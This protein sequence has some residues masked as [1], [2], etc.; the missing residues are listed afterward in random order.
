M[1]L[2]PKDFSKKKYQ[3]FTPSSVVNKILDDLGYNGEDILNKTILESSCG[4]GNFLVEIVE[5]FIRESRKKQW[6]LRRIK[7][8]LENSI[9]GVE[10]DIELFN[11]CIESL[12]NIAMKHEIS[13]VNWKIVNGNGLTEY[14]NY[15]FDFNVGNPPYIRYHGMSDELR[16]YLKNNY[17]SCSKGSFDYFFAFVES[18]FN[19]LGLNGKM[20]FL[21]PG[22]ILTTQSA[23]ILRK[24]LYPYLYKIYD[25]K[26]KKIFKNINTSSVV[27]YLQK[28]KDNIKNFK[29]MIDGEEN[30][31]EI[32]KTS[33]TSKMSWSLNLDEKNNT[34]K[35]SSLFLAHAPIATQANDVFVINKDLIIK[36]KIEKKILKL[37]GSPKD[38]NK[39]EKTYIIFPY[40]TQKQGI[41]KYS[42]EEFKY[43]FP[44]ATKY[45]QIK[46]DR[47]SNRDADKNSQWFEYGRSQAL[48]SVYYSKLVL[49]TSISQKIK[50]YDMPKNTLASGGIVI[51]SIS[52][53]NLKVAKK[54]LTSEEFFIYAENRGV[55]LT[56]SYVRINS[57]LINNFCF[58]KAKL[59]E[60]V[61]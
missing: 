14:H 30:Y 51:K 55:S 46:R 43:N 59:D 42:E 2:E 1:K 39:S 60:W 54:I 34:I 15:N 3:I 11:K 23:S 24:I 21:L 8:G 36:Y 32:V 41:H 4:T 48:Q 7:K 33:D 25:F 5:R 47:L 35:F 16:N 6:N 27:I 12:N 61:K 26:Q 44:N 50:I 29:Y 40:K 10:K 38:F 37:N 17:E 19:K 56:G 22:S 18:G 57:T 13:G 45:L 28:N 53:F 52:H 9:Y 49:S 20:A 58:S 31:S